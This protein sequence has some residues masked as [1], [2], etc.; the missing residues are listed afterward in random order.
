MTGIVPVLRPE[1]SATQIVVGAPVTGNT[2]QALAGLGNW[3]RGKGA[4]LVP[5]CTPFTTIT[6]AANETF[7]FR[8]K[9]RSSAIQRVWVLYA[10]TVS[11]VS[12]LTIKAPGASGT[13]LTS[14]VSEIED[15]RSPIVYV[16][17]LSSQAATEQQI[18]INIAAAGADVLVEAISCYEQDRPIL[19]SDSTDYGVDLFTCASGQP[20]YDAANVSVGGAYDA[21]T[22]S[23]ARR[24][25]IFHW[26]QG[27]S[28]AAATASGTPASLLTLSIPVLVRKLGRSDVTGSVKWAAYAKVT[29]GT[30]TITLTHT[31]DTGTFTDSA[32]VTG[33][34]YAWTS[35]RTVSSFDC[36]DLATGDGLPGGWDTVNFEISASGGTLTV[37][38]ISVWQDD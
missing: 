32:S 1:P 31:N 8:V 27:D 3:L 17:N 14:S 21:L 29:A 9:T 2:W 34:S 25:G 4:M 35:A 23:D 10:R 15:Y 7:R 12:T 37:Q 36:D 22:N 19:Q 5:W 11:S 28:T 33:T 6:A 26:T 16:E 38:S 30:G 24:V 20:I 18:D 13:A